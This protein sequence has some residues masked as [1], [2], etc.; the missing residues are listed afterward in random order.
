M[1]RDNIKKVIRRCEGN[2]KEEEMRRKEE[3]GE[4]QHESNTRKEK[5]SFQFQITLVFP[6]KRS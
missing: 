2:K 6:G 1:R 4:E 5:R 3:R